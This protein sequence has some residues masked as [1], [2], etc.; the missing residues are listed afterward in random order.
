MSVSHFFK[1]EARHWWRELK[2]YLNDP[3]YLI[4]NLV[5]HDKYEEQWKLRVESERATKHLYKKYQ[6]L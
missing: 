2:F 5:S 4:F 1:H 6:E 3:L